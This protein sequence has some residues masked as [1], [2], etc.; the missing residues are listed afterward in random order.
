MRNDPGLAPSAVEELVRY[1]S[2]V[3][4]TVRFPR[5]E[6][7]FAGV[8]VRPGELVAVVLGAA[9]RD[10]DRFDDPDRLDLN[11]SDNHHLSFG[12]GTHFCL[13]SQLARMEAQIAFAAI[14]ER[15]PDL[16]LTGD[17]LEWGD[18]VVLRGL[19]SLPLRF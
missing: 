5:E 17:H 11:R 12:H 13:G 1:D 2:P 4:V 19:R 9:N 16:R 3:Q 18:N 8:T 15:F 7:D 6:I 14:A 10:P